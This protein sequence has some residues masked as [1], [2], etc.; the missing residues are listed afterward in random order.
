MRFGLLGR[1]EL[2]DEGIAIEIA[3]AKQRALLAILLLDANRVVSSEALI[4]ALWEQ[5]AP[6]TAAKAL[7]V[8]VSQLRKLLGPDRVVTRSPG[9]ALRVE[10]GELDLHE[11]EALVGR[12][13]ES[14]PA[15]ASA[16]LRE[17]LALWRGPPLADFASH[18]FAQSEIARLDEVRLEAVED[19]LEAEL[20][21]GEHRALVGELDALVGKHPLRE[22]LRGQLMLALYRSGRQAEAL[23]SYQHGRNVFVDE[24]GIEPGRSLREL[25][26]QILRQDSRLDLAVAA[27]STTET[28]PAFVGRQAE[29]REP[30]GNTH[31]DP[32][33]GGGEA[34][35]VVTVLFSDV[36]SS[37]ALGRRARPRVASHSSCPASS[38]RCRSRCSS[39]T[40]ARSRSSSATQS[41]RSSAFPC[42]RGRRAARRT[43]GS[44]DA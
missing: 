35:K 31:P 12:A 24:L 14:P 13:R 11:F 43:R 25:H 4:D 23:E 39:A 37:T 1:L 18:R 10:E 16:I 5:Q 38:R 6:E 20:S 15:E 29:R 9:Y 40:G 42:S 34:R 32:Q 8:H 3:G 2:S 44:R 36:T 33:Q 26:Q 30:V 28:S 21:L 7:Q 19:R 22:R 17:A 27:E 41:W